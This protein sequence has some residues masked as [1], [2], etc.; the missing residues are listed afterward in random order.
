MIQAVVLKVVEMLLGSILEKR[1]SEKLQVHH[2]RQMLESR[3]RLTSSDELVLSWI[4]R[5][6]VT[7]FETLVTQFPDYDCI[8]KRVALF[9][10]LGFVRVRGEI[11][12]LADDYKAIALAVAKDSTDQTVVIPPREDT[13]S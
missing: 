12:E 4:E 2:E 10:A 1:D 11:I 5:N 13:Q 7:T 8:A 9:A 3:A 6:E